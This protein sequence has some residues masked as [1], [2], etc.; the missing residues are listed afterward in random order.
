MR[1]HTRGDDVVLL[2]QAIATLRPIERMIMQLRLKGL[3][4]P[5]IAKRMG[6][7]N[8]TVSHYYYDCALPKLRQHYPKLRKILGEGE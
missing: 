7:A 4:V 1:V 3:S 5:E 8:G 6:C 2:L